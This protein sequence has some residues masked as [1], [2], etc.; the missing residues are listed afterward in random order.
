MTERG[1]GMA[2]NPNKF[3]PEELDHPTR[4]EAFESPKRFPWGLVAAI[5][6]ILCLIGLAYYFFR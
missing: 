1:S 5:I 3:P 6:V 2:A 4:E